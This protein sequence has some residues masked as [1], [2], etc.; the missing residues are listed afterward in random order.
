[1]QGISTQMR[2][3][4]FFYGVTLGE[5]IL[6]HTD[7]LSSTLQSKTISAAEGQEIAKMTIETLKSTQ[8]D[9]S[10]DNFSEYVTHRVNSIDVTE[11]ILPRQHDQAG[12]MMAYL[13]EIFLILQKASSDIFILKH[14]TSL[15]I[16]LRNVLIN[17]VTTNTSN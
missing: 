5:M 9:E 13:V 8:T 15:L 16:V 4:Q 10:F 7:N 3:F 14:W 12:I 11:P 6:R 1:M 17:L 2:T